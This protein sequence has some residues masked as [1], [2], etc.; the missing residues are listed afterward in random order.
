M[1][2]LSRNLVIS[3]GRKASASIEQFTVTAG[4]VKVYCYQ[5]MR[6]EWLGKA[7]YRLQSCGFPRTVELNFQD[8]S[9]KSTTRI[10]GIFD[11]KELGGRGGGREGVA[12]D[13]NK[14]IK[15]R[16]VTSTNIH[17]PQLTSMERPLTTVDG[18]GAGH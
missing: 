13:V 6:S 7:V 10:V 4:L 1:L 9:K 11:V 5:Y 15:W 14:Q 12:I 18:G 16:Q 2:N 17:L 8:F 3:P